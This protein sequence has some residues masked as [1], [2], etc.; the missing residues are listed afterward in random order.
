MV[1]NPRGIDAGLRV[2]PPG[3]NFEATVKI[4]VTR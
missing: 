1:L 4:T 2:L 3:A